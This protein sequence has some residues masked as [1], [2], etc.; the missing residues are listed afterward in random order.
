M[1]VT[2]VDVAETTRHV[3]NTLKEIATQDDAMKRIE[4]E[5]LSMREVWDSDAEKAY[6]EQFRP[7]KEKADGFNETMRSYLNG[8]Q[9]F[10]D[11]CAATDASIRDTLNSVS[12]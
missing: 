3:T 9:S 12:W 10:V 2:V 4:E 11:D 1:A 6:E 7:S 5:V 8:M